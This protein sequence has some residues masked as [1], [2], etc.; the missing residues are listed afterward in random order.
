APNPGAPQLTFGGGATDGF[1]TRIDTLSLTPC[2]T[3]PTSHFSTY[4]GG[5]G[6]DSG[7]G[8]AIDSQNATYVAGE[9]NS[10]N[11]PTINPLQAT[12]SGGS[13]AFLTK[14]GSSINLSVT[15]AASPSPVGVGNNVTFTYTITNNGDITSGITFT[16]TLASSGSTLV[17]SPT[18]SPGTCGAVV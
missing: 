17:G 2:C 5:S 18:S 4:L 15:A 14:L 9:T 1:A 3:T 11:F 6:T 12:L 8:I 13:D 10:G 16:D 7:T